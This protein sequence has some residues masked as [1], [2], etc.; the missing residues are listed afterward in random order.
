MREHPIRFANGR[1]R[2]GFLGHLDVRN[3][4]RTQIQNWI[5]ELESPEAGIPTIQSPAVAVRLILKQAHR[6]GDISPRTEPS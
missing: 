6:E 1:W 4:S 2:P 5:K 3:I